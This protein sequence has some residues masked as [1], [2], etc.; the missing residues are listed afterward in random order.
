VIWSDA[1]VTAMFAACRLL[2]NEQLQR[3]ASF[4][5]LGAS[6]ISSI[7]PQWQEAVIFIV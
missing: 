1:D 2:Q 5:P 6:P 3:A 4:N 7:A